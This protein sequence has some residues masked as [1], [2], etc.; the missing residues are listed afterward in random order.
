MQVVVVEVRILQ[1]VQVAVEQA[2]VAL[3]E[4]VKTLVFLALQTLAAAVEVLT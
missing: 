1:Q 4:L 3:L 2:A